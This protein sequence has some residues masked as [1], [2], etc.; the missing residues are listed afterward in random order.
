[1]S[2]ETKA[3][4]PSKPKK[5]R[6]AQRPPLALRSA[7]QQGGREAK[8]T[9]AA[10]LEVLAGMRLPSEAAQALEIALPRYYLLEVRALKGLVEA[11]EPRP[12]GRQVGPEKELEALRKENAKLR[13]ECNRYAALTRASQRAVGLALPAAKGKNDKSGR[14]RK[15]R[16]KTPTVRALK[17]VERLRSGLS[18]ETEAGA[19]GEQ[20]AEG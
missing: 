9:A 6:K 4:T 16:R 1:M 2:Q 17:V 5:P 18:G 7:M 19:A 11:C 8:R 10:I 15:R 3:Q 20:P 13:Q 12:L 14:D